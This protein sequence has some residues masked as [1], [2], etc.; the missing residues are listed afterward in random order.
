[1]LGADEDDVSG[2]NAPDGSASLL[3]SS[4]DETTVQG[5]LASYGF[6]DAETAATCWLNLRDGFECRRMDETGEKRLKRLAPDL[7]RAIA[8]SDAQ[9]ATL[10]RVLAVVTKILRRST[11]LALLHER[12]LAV[13]H[14]V[15]LCA[16]SPW[17]S[18]ELADQPQL[19]DEL[20]DARTLYAPPE[21][22]SLDRDL[23]EQLA[24]VAPGDQEHGMSILR[25]FRHRQVL[26]VA[27]A[28]LVGFAALES[29]L[30]QHGRDWER[31]AY[32]KA[33][34]VGPRPPNHVATELHDD[35]I[36][37]FV[38]R[39]YLDFGVFDSLREMH[40]LIAAE[41]RRRELADN[42]KLGPGGLE[43]IEFFVQW[44]LLR[45]AHRAEGILVQNTAA[46]LHRLVRGGFLPP[47]DGATL[48][49]AYEY[50]RRLETFLRLNEEQVVREDGPVMDLAARFMGQDSDYGSIAVGKVADFAIVDGNPAERIVDLWFVEDVIRAGVPYRT[51][52][53]R[54][55]TGWEAPEWWTEHVREVTGR[56][57]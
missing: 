41:V 46:A 29:Y 55:A 7:L 49:G 23:G 6:A 3:M 19:L 45:N 17:I 1:M 2:E 9:Q 22:A 38:Y 27:A 57:P 52:D 51:E 43:D 30:V 14:L 32:V 25:Q 18:R 47:D 4:H 16:A 35:M 37:P 15:R 42:I 12:P 56:E 8:R 21:R 40:E 39:R 31:Y 11:Y 34:I 44:L 33:R 54:R 26:R 28:A 53:L 5:L 36:V 48:S 24:A 50:F 13:S 20:L 10:E